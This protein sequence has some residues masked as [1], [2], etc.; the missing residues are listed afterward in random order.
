MPSGLV[1]GGGGS[2]LVVNGVLDA[3]WVL[4]LTERRPIGTWVVRRLEL[5]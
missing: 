4:G 3:V 1:L 5:G 2:L